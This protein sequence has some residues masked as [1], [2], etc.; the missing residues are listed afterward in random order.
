MGLGEFVKDLNVNQSLLECLKDVVE[1]QA[2][3]VIGDVDFL[4]EK[5]LRR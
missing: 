2:W 3:H 5:S 1:V 4:K